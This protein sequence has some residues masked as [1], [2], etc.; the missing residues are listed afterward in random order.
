MGISGLI[1]TITILTAIFGTS[2]SAYKIGK[3][4]GE[5]K[6]QEEFIEMMDHERMKRHLEMISGLRQMHEEKTE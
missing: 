2:I 5:I 6:A 1:T 3:L 4:E